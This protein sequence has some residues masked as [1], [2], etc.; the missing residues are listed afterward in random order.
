[1]W[2]K[3]KQDVTVAIHVIKKACVVNVLNIIGV[4]EKFLLVSF[5]MKWK[6]PIIDL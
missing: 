4:E 5:Q 2:K 3:T 6:K 1:M